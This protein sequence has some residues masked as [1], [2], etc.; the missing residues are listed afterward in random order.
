M[1]LIGIRAV[2]LDLDN[3]LIDFEA[4]AKECMQKALSDRGIPFREEIYETF[5]R[6]NPTLWKKIERKELTLDGL[7][8]IRWNMVF[9]EV[10]LSQIDGPLFEIDFRKYLKTSGIPIEGAVDLLEDLKKKGYLLC[11]ASNGPYEQQKSRMKAAGMDDFISHWFVSERFGVNKPAGEFFEAA[12]AELE[13]ITPPE[14]VM[15]GDSLSADIAGGKNFGMKT[16][17]YDRSGTG[18]ES[19]ADRRVTRLSEIKEILS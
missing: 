10:G 7:H 9:A 19:H 2:L 5:F 6:I 4:S 15:I 14:C 11:V 17:W 8:Q 1:K 18:E 12:M 3:T 16:V 13:G